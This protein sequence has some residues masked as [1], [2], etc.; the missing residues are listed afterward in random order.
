MEK[1]TV[2][3]MHTSQHELNRLGC[4]KTF[5]CPIYCI[6]LWTT[7]LT[8]SKHDDRRVKMRPDAVSF[9]K[10][11]KKCPRARL[12]LLGNNNGWHLPSGK[13]KTILRCGLRIDDP[14]VICKAHG[15]R[16]FCTIHLSS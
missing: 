12:L 5:D 10:Q 11:R 7:L 1:L 16:I 8:P 3:S 13:V 2:R 4:P 9:A 14:S 6:S 15:Y